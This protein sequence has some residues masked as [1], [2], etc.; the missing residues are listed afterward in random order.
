[1]SIWDRIKDAGAN[2][3][4]KMT[5]NEGLFQ[6]GID[7]RI[8]G[9]VRDTALGGIP[10]EVAKAAIYGPGDFARTT[11][12]LVKDTGKV[13]GIL[14]ELGLK[15]LDWAS[16]GR[17][18]DDEGLFQ[19]GAQGKPLGRLRD[20]YNV[21]RALMEEGYGDPSYDKMTDPR[22]PFNDLATGSTE[23]STFWGDSNYNRNQA[24]WFDPREH[25]YDEYNQSYGGHDPKM[26]PGYEYEGE[27]V[28]RWMTHG[29][30]YD[31]FNEGF[32]QYHPD[33]YYSNEGADT[34][35]DSSP[36]GDAMNRNMVQPSRKL[37]VP[38][39]EDY[40]QTGGGY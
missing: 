20:V 23:T 36:L 30:E 34:V 21:P 22:Y 39:V 33:P 17:L 4:E 11:G 38:T 35:F 29:S 12:R 18:S 28:P 26:D 10:E 19:G 5:D 13:A 14:G 2:W 3:K 16:G 9:R 1:M 37:N 32:S 27:S 40:M 8:F 6:G 7:D 24:G 15:G 31:E 25:S